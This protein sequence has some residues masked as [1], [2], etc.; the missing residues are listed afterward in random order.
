[1]H[2]ILDLIIIQFHIT[3]YILNY[4][5]ITY[6]SFPID[7]IHIIIQYLILSLGIYRMTWDDCRFIFHAIFF[8]IWN[9]HRAPVVNLS[10]CLLTLQPLSAT[11]HR[12]MSSTSRCCVSND[13]SDWSYFD[14]GKV[15]NHPLSGMKFGKNRGT[16]YNKSH[17]QDPQVILWDIIFF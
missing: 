5:I 7:I 15:H 16:Y 4:I 9:F 17:V 1:M 14:Y 13:G 10:M 2:F 12:Y 8:D 3:R 11:A 6:D